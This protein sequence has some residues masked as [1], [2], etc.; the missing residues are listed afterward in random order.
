MNIEEDI[1]LRIIM[2]AMLI[3]IKQKH[4]FCRLYLILISCNLHIR[5]A[6]RKNSTTKKLN[7]ISENLSLG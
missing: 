1:K 5:T 2:V 7:S 4:S 6:G 3:S